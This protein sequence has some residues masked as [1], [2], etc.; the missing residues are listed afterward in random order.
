MTVGSV[1]NTHVH[2]AI[3]HPS[4]LAF[5]R[6]LDLRLGWVFRHSHVRP[7]FPGCHL[8]RRFAPQYSELRSGRPV[9]LLHGIPSCTTCHFT[10]VVGWPGGWALNPQRSRGNVHPCCL[11]ARCSVPDNP[12]S[13]TALWQSSFQSTRRLVGETCG[14]VPNRRSPPHGTA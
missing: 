9:P 4:L 11:P 7:V 5:T 6:N 1:A 14:S 3:T 8:C 13:G 2:A 12:S 10:T